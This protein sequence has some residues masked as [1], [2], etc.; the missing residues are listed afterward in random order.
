MVKFLRLPEVRARRG[1]SRSAHYND[2]AEGTCTSPVALG[3]R[4]VGWPEDEIEALN[5]ARLAGADDDEVRA[6]VQQLHAARRAS[7]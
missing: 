2:I 1:R 3:A 4:S 6:L 7:K 5:A